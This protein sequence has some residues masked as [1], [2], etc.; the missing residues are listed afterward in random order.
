MRKLASIQRIKKIAPIDGADAIVKATVLGWQVVVKRGEF[1]EGDLCVYVEIDSVLPEK[2]AFEFLRSKAFRIR[3]IRLRGQISQGICFPLSILPIDRE[4][5]EGMD[6]TELLGI[7]KYEMPIPP[8]LAGVMK[9]GFPSFIPKTD[10]ERVQVVEDLLLQHKGR[11]CYIT[12]KLDGTSITFYIKDGAFGVCSR[13]M[14]LMD[15]DNLYW[16]AARQLNIEARL[17]SVGKN[18]AL[19]GELVGEGIQGNKLKINGR[20]V[21]FF[22]LFWI[23]NYRY[24]SFYELKELLEALGLSMVPVVST[25]YQ[26]N[27]D[28][29][30]ILSMAQMQSALYSAAMAEGVVVRSIDG[31]HISFKAINNNFLLKWNE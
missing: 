21:Y 31:E 23:D 4:I 26:L 17:R 24:A 16:N 1:N 14:E 13:N 20:K 10:E 15:G 27:A 30:E 7:K 18:I 6:A 2:P 19:Q 5:K 12:E 25:C 3:T 28:V 29:P 22:S 8:S 9:S 11:A